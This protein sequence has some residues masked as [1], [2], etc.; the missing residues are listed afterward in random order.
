[1]KAID[2]FYEKQQEPLRSFYLA[3]REIILKHDENISHSLK[4]GMPFFSYR[5]KM[6]CYFWLHR[7]YQQPYIGWVEGNHFNHP[8]LLI[9]K[10]SRMKIYLLDPLQ[11]IPVDT[12]KS[13]L[14]KA[15]SLYTSGLVKI[16]SK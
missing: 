12:I 1:M 9:E 8:D 14:D 5:G 7:K 4:Y 16:I 6:F 13:F 2:E 11:D 15:I 3:L 10:R